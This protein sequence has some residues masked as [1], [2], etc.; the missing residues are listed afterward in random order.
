[1]KIRKEH[2]FLFLLVNSITW[3]SFAWFVIR[4]YIAET[5]FY[6]TL[7]VS[8]SYYGAIIA[9]TVI[10]ATLLKRELRKK[11]SLLI[12]VLIGACFCGIFASLVDERVVLNFVLM[13]FIL[14]A[15]V[16]V[17]IPTCLSCFADYTE[18]ENRGRIGATLF[19]VIQLLTVLIYTPISELD[20]DKK[21]LILAIWRLT[22]LV[23]IFFYKPVGKVSKEEISYSLSSNHYK[24]PFIFYFAPW[25]LFCLVNF[26][27]AP[28]LLEF[29]GLELFNTYMMIEIV[30]IS[31]SAFI[32]GMLCDFKGR[33]NTSI[34][35]F[36]M[37]GTGYAIL[38]LFSE[39]EIAQFIY[40]LTDGIAWGFLYVAFI[41]VIWGDLSERSA[42]EKY[43]LVGGMPFLL[44]GLIEVFVQPFVEMIPID[45]SFSFASFFLFAAVLPLM[46]APETLPEKHI[47]ERELRSYV[48]KAKKIREKFT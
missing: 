40:V 14:G 9:F 27:E 30:I 21:F 13:A 42:R 4:D 32:G 48:E 25:F 15:S 22:G 8:A 44:S 47:R 43:Y 24:N 45:T 10:G 5:S 38:S 7:L 41:F 36:I 46:F 19:F 37:L 23:S 34:L 26:L 18:I 20:I 6:E 11:E 31:I 33:K 12:W 28:L 3:F 39:V 2:L 17:G 16:G 35:G 29:F 1:M